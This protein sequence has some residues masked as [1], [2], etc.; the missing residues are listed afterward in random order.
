MI[1]GV[2]I[3]EFHA[4]GIEL[5]LSMLIAFKNTAMTCLLNSLF[6]RPQEIIVCHFFAIWPNLG[7]CGTENTKNAWSGL[8]YF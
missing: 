3:Y 7:Y 1:Y 6:Y 8:R 2:N 4:R 5:A